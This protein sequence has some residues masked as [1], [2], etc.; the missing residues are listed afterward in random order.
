MP[1]YILLG[2]VR[3]EGEDILGVYLTQ[4]TADKAKT[5]WEADPEHYSSFY[6]EEWEAE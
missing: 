4:E 1:V 6:V 2:L 5:K 3:Y